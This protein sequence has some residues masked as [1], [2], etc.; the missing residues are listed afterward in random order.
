MTPSEII[1]AEVEK[2]GGD[3]DQ[4][5]Q[6]VMYM[7]KN[8]LAFLL[9]TNQ[10]VLLLKQLGDG[11]VESHLFTQDSPSTLFKSLQFFIEKIR[12]SEVRAIYGKATNQQIIEALKRL[13]VTVEQSDREEYNW[14]A[15]V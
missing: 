13:G 1:G 9:H 2:Q 3:V 10:S 6:T 4:F 11:D 5:K 8:N 15:T 7:L 14:K 12:N